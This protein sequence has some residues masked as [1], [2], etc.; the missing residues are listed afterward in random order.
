MTKAATQPDHK[1]RRATQKARSAGQMRGPS[2][3]HQGGELLAKAEILEQKIAVGTE[4]RGE[5]P[6]LSGTRYF[7]AL[8]AFGRSVLPVPVLTG[9]WPLYWYP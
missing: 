9:T 7:L 5:H 4:G 6:P 1:R 8:A 3:R 2:P